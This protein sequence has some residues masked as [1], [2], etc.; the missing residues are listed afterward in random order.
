[1]SELD[2]KIKFIKSWYIHECFNLG[3]S[4]K[5][6]LARVWI[7]ICINDEEYEMAAA[8]KSERKNII[9]QHIQKKR[10][11]RKFGEK[12]FIRLFLIKRKIKNLF[13]NK[14]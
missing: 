6:K 13:K 2:K 1:M 10:K 7:K 4:E 12:I 14:L 9:K 8:I 11:N 3:F 5:L